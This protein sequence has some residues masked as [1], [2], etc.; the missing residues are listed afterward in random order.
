MG[1]EIGYKE[2]LHEIVRREGL[3]E[4]TLFLGERKDISDLMNLSD[5]IVHA[6]LEP[7]PWGLVVAEGMAA[8]RAVVASAAGGPLE[9][10]EHGR[11]GLLVPPG[12]SAALAEA[13]EALL[14]NP[15]LRRQMGEAARRHAEEHF[16]SHHA[17]EVLCRELLLLGRITKGENGIGS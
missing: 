8:G 6:S 5:V 16:D 11:N 3:S 17:A 10:I 1:L 4:K 15:E 13:I 14:E 7:E 2:K 12:N 9:M